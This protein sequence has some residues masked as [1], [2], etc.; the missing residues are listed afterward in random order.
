MNPSLYLPLW[1]RDGATFIS[2]DGAGRLCTVTN[3]PVN[4]EFNC[5][6]FADTSKIA[7]TP[8]GSPSFTKSIAICLWLKTDLLPST[9]AGSY[10]RII[11][12]DD[13]NCGLFYTKT[14]NVLSWKLATTE[15]TNPRAAIQ[16]ASLS[17]S[18]WMFIVAQYLEGKARLFVDNQPINEVTRDGTAIS[19]TFNWILGDLTTTYNLICKLGDLLM[20]RSLNYEQIADIY[21]LT[22][23][24]YQ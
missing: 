23:W 10:A 14:G 17:K 19:S 1:K 16:E 6:N 20:F 13:D 2:D 3:A 21:R 18:R 11:R 9:I 8:A 22:R 24:R 15:G 5:R 7:I 4:K 12:T